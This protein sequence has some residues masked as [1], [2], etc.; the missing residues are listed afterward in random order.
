M[1]DKVLKTPLKLA[2]NIY[3]HRIDNEVT[4]FKYMK[5]N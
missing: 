5:K 3:V 2:A 4:T 1:F